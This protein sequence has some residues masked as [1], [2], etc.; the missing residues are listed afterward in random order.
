MPLRMRKRKTTRRECSQGCVLLKKQV[1]KINTRSRIRTSRRPQQRSHVPSLVKQMGNSI[2]SAPCGH[3]ANPS[4]VISIVNTSLEKNSLEFSCPVC[5]K[6]WEWRQVKGLMEISQAQ[7]AVL[8][9][10]VHQIVESHPDVYKKCPSCC[11]VLKRPLDSAGQPC[12]SVQC[13][14]CPPPRQLCWA[15]LSPWLFPN[16]AGAGHCSNGSCGLVAMLLNC[17]I[18]TDPKSKVYGCP[19]FRACPKCHGLIMHTKG[20]NVLA[21]V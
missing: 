17:D 8:E 11:C 4:N 19:L 14:Q 16:E 3:Q 20:C 13:P 9:E 18:V 1:G 21:L 7:M 6:A 10:R 12:L 5:R 2:Q 15:C